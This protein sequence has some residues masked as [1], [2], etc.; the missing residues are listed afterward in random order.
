MIEVRVRHN[1]IEKALPASPV[2]IL[3]INGASKAGDDFLVLDNEKEAKSLCNTRLQEAKEGKNPL[4]FVKKRVLFRNVSLAWTKLLVFFAPKSSKM[5]LF[6]SVEELTALGL[7][8]CN[9]YFS[10]PQIQMRKGIA[11]RFC[12]KSSINQGFRSF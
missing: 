2:E 4:N 10:V 3:G 9:V 11:F 12:S 1:N 5:K 7:R 6:L 8:K